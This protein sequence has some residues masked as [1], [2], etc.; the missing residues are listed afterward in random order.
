MAKHRFDVLRG[1]KVIA[2]IS[3]ENLTVKI[4]AAI[5]AVGILIVGPYPVKTK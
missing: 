3:A 2:H 4:T 1:N 5:A